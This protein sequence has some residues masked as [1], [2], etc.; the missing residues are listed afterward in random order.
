MKNIGA[1][2]LRP[3]ALP[4]VN[5]MRVMQYPKMVINITF[6]PELNNCTNLCVQFLH[7]TATFICAINHPLVASYDI[8]G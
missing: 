7:Q 1:G 8:P 2:I 4:G 5:H 3:H 6:W